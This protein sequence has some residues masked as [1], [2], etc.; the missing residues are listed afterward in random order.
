MPCQ[1]LVHR[2]F[3]SHHDNLETAL[4]GAG[5]LDASMHH[6]MRGIVPSHGIQRD[7][8]QFQLRNE[9]KQR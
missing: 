8:D 4:G 1:K 3:I 7:L 6:I 5:S 9:F 2:L